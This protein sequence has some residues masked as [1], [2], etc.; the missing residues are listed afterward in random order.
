MVKTCPPK[1][2]KFKKHLLSFTLS[3]TFLASASD[4]FSSAAA[5]VAARFSAATRFFSNCTASLAALAAAFLFL[6][7]NFASR[8]SA[9][10]VGAAGGGDCA[11][12]AVWHFFCLFYR[13]GTGG[14][15]LSGMHLEV[16]VVQQHVGRER[17]HDRG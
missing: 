8:L 9:A 2:A 1:F 10:A 6:A 13:C 14:P 15:G 17:W 7:A 5:L 11:M 3:R 16:V 4:F 12:L